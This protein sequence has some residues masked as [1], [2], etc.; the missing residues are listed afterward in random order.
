ME[1]NI[2]NKQTRYILPLLVR[3]TLSI[4]YVIFINFVYKLNQTPGNVKIFPCSMAE[5]TLQGLFV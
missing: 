1:G 5:P 2:E 3:D 4:L